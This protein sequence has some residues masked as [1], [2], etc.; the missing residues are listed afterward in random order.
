MEQRTDRRTVL[1]GGP[2]TPERP[3]CRTCPYYERGPKLGEGLCQRYPP[4]VHVVQGGRGI[5]TMQP[6]VK[7]DQSCGEHPERVQ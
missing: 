5:T 2:G 1:R 7:Q 3:T 4:T 6:P